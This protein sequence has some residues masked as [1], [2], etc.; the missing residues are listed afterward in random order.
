MTSWYGSLFCI[1]DPLCW[2]FTG[3]RWIPLTKGQWCR[4]WC[5]FGVGPHTLLNKLYDRWFETTWCSCDV[6]VIKEPSEPVL[7]FNLDDS[8][9]FRP[10]PIMWGIVR[11][12]GSYSATQC[13][14]DT[15]QKIFHPRKW[16]CQQVFGLFFPG[17][18]ALYKL[19][20]I[21]AWFITALYF[22]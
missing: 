4:L 10:G 8:T 5:F 2:E 11:S 18:N 9:N 17:A 7:I 14:L 1:T 22:K 15:G 21:W 12:Y 19:C 3:H 20:L 6:I 13:Q 16:K